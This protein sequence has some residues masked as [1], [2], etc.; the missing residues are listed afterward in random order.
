MIQ[1]FVEFIKFSHYFVIFFTKFYGKA[2]AWPKFHPI[3]KYKKNQFMKT[4]RIKQLDVFVM[5]THKYSL[6][7]D[8]LPAKKKKKDK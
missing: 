5:S 4:Q 2:N 3:K 6:A 1:V 8:S 7:I